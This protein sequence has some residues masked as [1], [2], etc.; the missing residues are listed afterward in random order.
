MLYVICQGG[1][2]GYNGGQEEVLHLATSTDR[3]TEERLPF[4]FTDGHAVVTLSEF[5]DDLK[6]LGRID[7]PLMRSRYWFDTDEDPDRKRRRQAEFLV[8]GFVPLSCLLEI[9]VMTDAII[10]M[11]AETL[12]QD[13]ALKVRVRPSW[14]Y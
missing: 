8:H 10:R 7:W 5:Y 11:V 2:E 9:G 4:A 1:V 6:E 12:G 13:S 3:I 14:Y